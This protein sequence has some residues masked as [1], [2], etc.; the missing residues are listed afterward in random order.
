MTEG[1]KLANALNA[2]AAKNPGFD[3][4]KARA[5]A[6]RDEFTVDWAATKAQNGDFNPDVDEFE[7]FVLGDRSECRWQPGPRK[8]AGVAR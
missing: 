5:V 4:A 6:R 8:F 1:Q 3:Y 2:A 7:T